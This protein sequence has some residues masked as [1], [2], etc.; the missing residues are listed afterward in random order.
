MP[1]MQNGTWDFL[2]FT[3]VGKTPMSSEEEA[4]PATVRERK[5]SID[6]GLDQYRLPIT[7]SPISIGSPP[8]RVKPFVIKYHS[9][10]SWKTFEGHSE[11]AAI[12]PITACTI[13]S[14]YFSDYRHTILRPLDFQPACPILSITNPQIKDLRRYCFY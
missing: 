9:F 7:F 1:Q 11:I 8:T 3:N 12:C 6:R 10:Q 2:E 5:V 4:K 13:I 14:C